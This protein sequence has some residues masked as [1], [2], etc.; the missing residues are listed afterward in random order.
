ME[1]K[2]PTEAQIVLRLSVE[3]K[4][5]LV[6]A[7]QAEGEKLTDWMLARVAGAARFGPT[8]P[9]VLDMDDLPGRLSGNWHI[10]CAVRSD[11]QVRHARQFADKA[12][13]DRQSDDWWAAYNYAALDWLH[14]NPDDPIWATGAWPNGASV[15]LGQEALEEARRIL[16]LL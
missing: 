15:H 3:A 12:I 6:K 1:D 14:A 2:K 7:S 4:N 11:A 10:R 13:A 8:R 5:A 9:A 16:G